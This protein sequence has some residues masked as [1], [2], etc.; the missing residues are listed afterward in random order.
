MLLDWFKKNGESIVPEASGNVRRYV[1]QG[2]LIRRK[3]VP[4]PNSSRW[5]WAYRLPFQDATLESYPPVVRDPVSKRIGT[6]RRESI[7]DQPVFVPDSPR[8]RG[9]PEY[10]YHLRNLGR[11]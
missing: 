5:V 7:F 8:I 10:V 11:K 6:K 4:K 3:V 9:E 1:E 2:R